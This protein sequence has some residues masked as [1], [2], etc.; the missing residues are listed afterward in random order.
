MR[1]PPLKAIEAVV[2]NRVDHRT[3]RLVT[4]FRQFFRCTDEHGNEATDEES[5]AR[6]ELTQRGKQ[7]WEANGGG[8]RR[9]PEDAPTFV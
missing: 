1:I 3:K 2:L 8:R 7:Y 6:I 5:I 9:I 4:H